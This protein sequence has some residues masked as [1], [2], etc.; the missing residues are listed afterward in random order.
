MASAVAGLMSLT[1]FWGMLY[2]YTGKSAGTELATSSQ[3]STS[4]W[5]LSLWNTGVTTPMPSAPMATACR[6]SSMVSAR[7]QA[8]TCTNTGTRLLV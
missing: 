8:P 3:K 1:A 7:F 5:S 4:P 6:A 2:R